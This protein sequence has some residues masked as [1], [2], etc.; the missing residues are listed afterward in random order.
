MDLN[1]LKEKFKHKRK[2][3]LSDLDLALTAVP[4]LVREVER[5]EAELENNKSRI[6]HLSSLLNKRPPTSRKGKRGEGTWEVRIDED[7]NRLYMSLSGFFNYQS[8]KEAS[9]TIISLLTSLR[10][11]GDAINDLRELKGFDQRAL[12]HIRKVFYTLDYVGVKRVVRVMRDDPQ[13]LSHLNPIYSSEA[14]YQMSVAKSVEDA[15][16]ILDQSRQFLKT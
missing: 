15:E 12:F 8:A 13:L 3:E 16:A 10:E 6:A 4:F 1:L 11:N 7:K 5:L 2:A 9:N 14:G